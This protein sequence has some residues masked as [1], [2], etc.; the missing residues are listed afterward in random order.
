MNWKQWIHTL[1]KFK[2]GVHLMRTHAA[3]T[4][5]LNCAYLGVPCIG[6]KGL[7]TQQ[8]CHP[9]CTV[10]IGDIGKAKEIINKLWNDQEFYLHC[11]N[12]GKDNYEKYF[13]EKNFKI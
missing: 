13:S 8:L 6:Y 1:N 9:D 11:S 2:V 10:E 3:G 4:F 5:A 12:I 7:D